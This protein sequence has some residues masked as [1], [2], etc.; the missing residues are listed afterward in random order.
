MLI[1]YPE[2]LNQIGCHI[3]I[4]VYLEI[5]LVGQGTLVLPLRKG[6]FCIVL[7]PKVVCVTLDLTKV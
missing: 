6:G 3:I 5:S 1:I 2:Q 4:A 7:G